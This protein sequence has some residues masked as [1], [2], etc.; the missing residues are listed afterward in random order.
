MV[1]NPAVVPNAAD[2]PPRPDVIEGVLVVP[3]PPE[4][5]PPKVLEAGAAMEPKVE[6]A[7]GVKELPNPPPPNA[8]P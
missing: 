4:A 3:N 2:P 8:P 6:E 5:A 1:G 7:A